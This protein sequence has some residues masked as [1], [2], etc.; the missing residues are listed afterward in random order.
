MY[1][2]NYMKLGIAECCHVFKTLMLC[3][4]DI[5]DYL[6]IYLHYFFQYPSMEKVFEVAA[7]KSD[8]DDIDIS[9][10]GQKVS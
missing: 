6:I 3:L 5:G 8:V 7:H 1:R 10:D 4:D 2:I 9:P